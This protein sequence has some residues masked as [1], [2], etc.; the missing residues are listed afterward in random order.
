MEKEYRLAPNSTRSLTV[1]WG[2][3]G[4]KMAIYRRFF[5]SKFQSQTFLY[6]SSVFHIRGAGNLGSVSGA[7]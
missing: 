4:G 6:V 5:M 2:K 7:L 1:K 3:K